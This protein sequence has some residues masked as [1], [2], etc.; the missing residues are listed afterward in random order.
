MGD[1][2]MDCWVFLSCA[3]GFPLF[4]FTYRFLTEPDYVPLKRFEWLFPIR[5]KWLRRGIGSLLLLLCL[6]L[7]APCLLAPFI[8]P[9]YF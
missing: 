1:T 8:G 7:F 3:L 5:G 6:L 2:L 4:A 9:Y